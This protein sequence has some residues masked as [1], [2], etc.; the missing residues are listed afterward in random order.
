MKGNLMKNL[1]ACTIAFFLLGNPYSGLAQSY[2]VDCE[3]LDNEQRRLNEE[4]ALWK[5]IYPFTSR[6]LLSC[7]KSAKTNEDITA[8]M[9]TACGMASMGATSGTNEGC[10]DFTA[11]IVGVGTGSDALKTRKQN[12]SYCRFVVPN[13]MNE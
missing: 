7:G 1:W 6:T 2:S 5:R 13:E 8:C 10:V 9:A 4:Y 3:R 11:R 12:Y